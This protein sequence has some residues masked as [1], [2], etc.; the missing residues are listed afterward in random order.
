MNIPPFLFDFIAST[1]A[2]RQSLIC[3][4]AFILDQARSNIAND[5]QV[6]VVAGKESLPACWNV[7]IGGGSQ[8]FVQV[9]ERLVS[10]VEVMQ[11]AVDEQAMLATNFAGGW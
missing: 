10:S 3:G 7:F 4:I 8:D 1:R 11:R 9:R 2:W 6:L 5:L